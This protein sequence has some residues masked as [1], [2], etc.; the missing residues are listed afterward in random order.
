MTPHFSYLMRQNDMTPFH[1][2]TELII[3]TSSVAVT[4]LEKEEKV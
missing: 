1:E 3:N 4:F 2:G